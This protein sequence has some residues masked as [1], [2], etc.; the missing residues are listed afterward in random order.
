[1]ENWGGGVRVH[2]CNDTDS[3]ADPEYHLGGELLNFGYC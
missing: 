2:T 1:M 3:M